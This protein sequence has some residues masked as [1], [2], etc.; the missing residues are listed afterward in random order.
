MRRNTNCNT[1]SSGIILKILNKNTWEWELA[2]EE[3][4]KINQKQKMFDV[5]LNISNISDRNAL[6][7]NLDFFIDDNNKNPHI[8]AHNKNRERQWERC[9]YVYIVHVQ[10]CIKH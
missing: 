7:W 8:F 3:K 1:I 10:K 6:E 4:Q 9:K 2:N 5:S